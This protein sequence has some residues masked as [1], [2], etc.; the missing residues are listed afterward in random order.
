[1][2]H[3]IERVTP[4]D[5]RLPPNLLLSEVMDA[6]IL[7]DGRAVPIGLPPA[8]IAFH[9]PDLPTVTVTGTNQD[10]ETVT[11]TIPVIPIPAAV[12]EP[13]PANTIAGNLVPPP[14]PASAERE[15]DSASPSPA[16]SQGTPASAEE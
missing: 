10:G 4:D 3:P 8:V 15:P 12:E 7:P 14:E 6:E 9:F 5:R 16:E 1:M 13:S 11:E 2:S